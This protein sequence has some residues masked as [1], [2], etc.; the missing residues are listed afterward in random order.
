[1]PA[2]TGIEGVHRVGVAW[3]RLLRPIGRQRLIDRGKIGLIHRLAAPERL[4]SWRFEVDFFGYRYAGDIANWVDWNVYFAGAYEPG[5]LAF[6][7]AAA[8]AVR[9]VRGA[10]HYVDVGANVGH[11]ALFMAA[12]AERVTAFEPFPRVAEEIRRKIAA[13]GLAHLALHPVG[14]GDADAELPM[15]LPDAANLG[16]ASFAADQPGRGARARIG[17]LPVRRGDA[18]FE[19]E[20]LPRIDMLKVDVQGFEAKVFAGLAERL[21]ADRPVVVTELSGADRSG[22]GTAQAFR[23]ALYP[24]H[25]LFTLRHGARGYRL[26]PF[27]LAAADVVVVPAELTLPSAGR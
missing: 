2:D 1:M 20:K 9:A 11:H 27:D 26:V 18:L 3:W 10:V 24:D 5:E 23:D 22:F 4:P 15:E 13:N 17:T 16:T 14:L 6:L 8:R 25:R 19:R 7:A 21:R 12:H